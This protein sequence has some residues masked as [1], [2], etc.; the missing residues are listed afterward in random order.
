MRLLYIPS[1]PADAAHP[2]PI[3]TEKSK[4]CRVE[5]ARPGGLPLVLIVEDRVGP[6]MCMTQGHPAVA[7]RAI[8]VAI[9]IV[10]RR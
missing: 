3:S 1:E 8:E 10:V 7:A 2:E 6:A 9:W 4:L 5:D